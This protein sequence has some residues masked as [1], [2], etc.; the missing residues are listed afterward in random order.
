MLFGISLTLFL[1]YNLV[2]VDPLVMIV[3]ERAMDDPVIVQ[4]ARE[5][6]GLDRPVWEQYLR[7][8]SNL[9]R[10]D[11]GVS[12]LTHRPVLDDLLLFLPATFELAVASLAFAIVL[13]IPLGILAGVKHGGVFDRSMWSLSLFNASLPPFWTGLIFLT[14]FYYNLGIMPGPGRLDPRMTSP[15]RVTGLLTIDTLLA[16]DWPGFLN[17]LHHLV[18]PTVILGG[19]TL[20]LVLRVT[21][22]AI[23]EELRKDY[24][25]TARSKGVSERR[26]VVGHALR[27]VLIPLITILGLA[28]AGLLSGA[29]M[30]ETV[31]DWP[32]IGQYLVRAAANLD[33]PAIQGGTL[34]IAM[35]YIVVNMVVDILYGVLDPRVRHE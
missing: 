21:R 14:I 28:F 7:Y 23:I 35:I 4:V 11:F 32:G 13:G 10:G 5:H 29:V 30:T 9:L 25:R 12:F 19:F 27:N 33:Y 2:Q 31:F 8:A 15:E 34:V 18:L 20:A 6:W 1:I 26:V 22:A 24:I 17:A 16:G 3:G